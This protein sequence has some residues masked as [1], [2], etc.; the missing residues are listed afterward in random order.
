MAEKKGQK[1]CTNMTSINIRIGHDD[2]FVIADFFNIHV[3]IANT[4]TKR[5]DQRANFNR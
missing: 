4:R 2:D 3:S 5:G 1:Q